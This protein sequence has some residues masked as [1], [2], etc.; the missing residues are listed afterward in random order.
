MSLTSDLKA[1]AVARGL[2]PDDRPLTA[3]AAFALV[4]D[5]P[6]ERASSRATERTIAEWRGTC[7]GKHYL[8]QAL[9]TEL[10]LRSTL[11]A[12]THEFTP[13]SAPWLPPPL[14]AEVVRRPL[15][16]VHNFLR[17]QPFPNTERADEW[18]T[19]D[20]T[21]PLTAASLGLPVNERFELGHDHQLACD[22]IEV[23][24]VPEEVDP[25]ELKE[26]LIAIHVGDQRDRREHF[27]VAL[28]EWLATVLRAR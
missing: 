23:F 1:G 3:P 25:Q 24:H 19:V 16:D 5:M 21:W 6:Y 10:G 14:L 27:L 17:L 20:A 15:P 22:P 9:F 7:S 18:M 12:C 4:R 26:R 28:S 13:E 11:I 2:F 8:L